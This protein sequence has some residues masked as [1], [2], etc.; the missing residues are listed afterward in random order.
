M[1]CLAAQYVYIGQGKM[2]KKQ[3]V[4]LEKSGNINAIGP[5][6]GES[7]T[8]VFLNGILCAAFSQPGNDKLMNPD[9]AASLLH[10]IW[11]MNELQPIKDLLNLFTTAPELR[12]GSKPNLWCIESVDLKNLLLKD[13]SFVYS[14]F[15]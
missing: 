10:N 13:D 3:V 1:K 8:T 9:Q 11:K 12:I 2:L 5:F 6:E 14:I 15:S 4:S 7:A